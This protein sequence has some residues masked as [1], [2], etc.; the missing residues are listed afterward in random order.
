MSKHAVAEN[1]GEAAD[2][3]GP[4][5]VVTIWEQYGAGAEAIG[6][7]VAAKLNLPYHEQAFSSEDIEGGQRGS[8]SGSLENRATLAQV[9]TAMGGAYGGFEG[10]DVVQTQREKRDLVAANNDTVWR[11]AEAGGVIVGRNATVILG[12]RP[13]TLHVLLTGE[14][15]DRV[16]RAA[17]ATGIPVEKAARRQG[18]EDQVRADISRVLYGWDP[19]D[20]ARY[21][22]VINTSRIP[23]SAVANAIVDAVES[24]R[25]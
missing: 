5:P 11:Y 6:R 17:Q 20:P 7:A 21:D 16:Q 8:D 2:T 1:A 24:S 4:K 18:R 22:L 14:V 10:R 19:Q 13:R 9:F 15:T 23:E 12:A 3:A 25:P